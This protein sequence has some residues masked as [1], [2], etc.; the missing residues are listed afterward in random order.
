MKNSSRAFANQ[1]FIGL[2]VTLCFGG[3]VGLGT[4]YMRHQ[5]SMTANANRALAARLAELRRHIDATEAQVETEQNYEALRMRNQQWRI[6]LVPMS[7]PQVTVVP[8]AEDPVRL[9]AIRANQGL[10][11]ESSTGVYFLPDRPVPKPRQEA[12]PRV[13]FQ[14]ARGR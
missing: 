7:D 2:L 3:S 6:G 12:P 8:V 4:V 11:D 9:M 13:T 10:F 14:V 1:L 5:I